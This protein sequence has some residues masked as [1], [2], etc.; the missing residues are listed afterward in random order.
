MTGK[1][2]GGLLA[3]GSVMAASFVV[4]EG[5]VSRQADSSRVTVIYWEKWTGAEADEMQKVVKAF[6]ESQNRILVRYLSISGV[7]SKTMLAT[8]GGDP[9]DVAGIWQEQVCQ[10]AD[11]HA[12]T[13]LTEMA[14]ASG[15]DENYYIKG[16]WEPLFYR[17]KLWAVPSTPASIALHVR[18]DLV[19]EDVNSAEK[20]PT[21]LEGLDKFSERVTVKNKDG[22]IKFAGFFPSWPGWW[23]WSWPQLF[24]GRLFDGK[25]L[26]IDS[27][28][29]ERAFEWIESYSQKYGL[30]ESQSFQSGFGNFA[31]PQDP[32]MEGKEATEMNGVWKG[33]YIEVYR[34]G[35]KWFAVPFPYPAD[36]PDL[37]DHAI[38]SQDVLTIPRGCKHPKEAF[39]FLRFVQRQDVMEGLCI[40][41]GKNSPL[42]KV[43]EHFFEAHPNHYIRLF[44]KLARSPAAFYPD[45]IGIMPQI[46]AE[47]DAVFQSVTTGQE[48]PKQAL[49]EAQTRL[50]RLWALYQDQVLG[51]GN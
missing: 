25:K 51:D 7:D 22:S 45:K 41:H 28:E 38:L 34:P 1:M 8:A 24:G 5:A 27:R 4:G 3:C 43:S 23:N 6:N 26:T 39:E 50:D 36:R 37:K 13:D 20:F 30:K 16:Y 49:A 42:A 21:T 14:K 11:A 48:K 31:S 40:G 47:M 18:P 17:N 12:L 29:A 2:V 19:P 10:F 33:K 44:D 32:F 46:R 35:L 15:L 9:P